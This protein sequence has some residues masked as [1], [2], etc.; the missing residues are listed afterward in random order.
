MFNFNLY[1]LSLWPEIFKIVGIAVGAY[2]LILFTRKIMPR[3]LGESFALIKKTGLSSKEKRAQ[4]RESTILSVIMS[5]GQVLIY[6]MAGMMILSEIGINIA[7]IIASAGIIGLALG[8]GAQTLVK[9]FING[10][11]IL[12]E[13][14]FSEGDL[15]QVGSL[16]GKVERMSLRSTLLRDLDGTLHVLPNSTISTVSNLSKQWAQVNLDLPFP[17]E[18]KVDD[19]YKILKKVFE[20]LNST[21]K[22][23]ELVLKKPEILGVEEMDMGK[24]VV[25]VV[26]RTQAL[27]QFEV[28]RRFRYL[29]KK[30][31]EEQIKS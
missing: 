14:Q 1:S 25:K 12:L 11:F 8:F 2:I 15:I 22:I 21:K 5:V 26:I 23:E 30:E 10:M 27:K 4:K 7:P 19:A 18:M 16:E 24:F 13:D 31:M 9:D 29:L 17:N 6:A 28:A 3:V 20:E